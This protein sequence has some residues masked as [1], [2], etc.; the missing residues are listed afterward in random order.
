MIWYKINERNGN[1]EYTHRY[2]MLGDINDYRPDKGKIT[3]EVILKHFYGDESLEYNET[4]GWWLHGECLVSVDG[5]VEFDN[6]AV[7]L[8]KTLMHKLNGLL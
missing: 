3:D 6:D 7:E 1:Y 8:Y 2:T 4:D 5:V